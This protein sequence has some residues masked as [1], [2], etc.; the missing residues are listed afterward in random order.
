[1]YNNNKK[2][3]YALHALLYMLFLIPLHCKKI[4]C[5]IIRYNFFLFDEYYLL[6]TSFLHKFLCMLLTLSC[7]TARLGNTIF[8]KYYRL[9]IDYFIFYKTCTDS[10]FK[11]FIFRL[12]ESQNNF[13][14][15]K[16]SFTS[17]PF[18]WFIN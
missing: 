9:D 10:Q 15:F 12:H 11:Y 17:L 6:L 18:S 5:R 4:F 1:M 14:K 13:W 7:Y 8:K 16:L 3:W 2:T